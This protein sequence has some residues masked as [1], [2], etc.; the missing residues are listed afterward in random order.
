MKN[1]INIHAVPVILWHSTCPRWKAAAG[2][3]E[4]NQG[5]AVMTKI[6]STL[7]STYRSLRQAWL[8]LDEKSQTIQNLTSRLVDE[9]ASLAN[10]ESSSETALVTSETILQI[11]K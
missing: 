9:E 8:S 10:D 2:D 11:V 7:P 1:S 5:I 4:Q 3:G 6:L